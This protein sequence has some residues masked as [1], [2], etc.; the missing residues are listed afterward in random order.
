MSDKKLNYNARQGL[1]FQAETPNFLRQLQAATS[2]TQRSR[3]D[4]PDFSADNDE[5]SGPDAPEKDDEKPQVVV[6]KGITDFEVKRYLGKDTPDE[7]SRKRAADGEED[8]SE[9]SEEEAEDTGTDGKV[10]F[11]K[12]KK[13]SSTSASAEKRRKVDE[14]KKA[15][16]ANTKKIKNKK[17]LS[18]DD[19]EG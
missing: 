2:G 14:K 3:R 8:Q 1:S 18:F 12:P 19:E 17:L 10:K 13:K 16:L 6:E 11:R 9:P 15:A 4:I 5:D 7:E